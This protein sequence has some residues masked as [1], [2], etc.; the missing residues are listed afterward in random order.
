MQFK[1]CIKLTISP[2]WYLATQIL[3]CVTK[4]AGHNSV[5][6]SVI[7]VNMTA[8][9]T[10]TVVVG[11]STH[12]EELMVGEV[13]ARVQLEDEHVVDAGWAPAVRVDAEQEDHEEDEEQPAVHAQRRRPVRHVRVP[14]E[15]NCSQHGGIRGQQTYSAMQ[16]RD[17]CEILT[18]FSTQWMG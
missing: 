7:N 13:V 17:Q 10:H 6:R 15:H 4:L 8:L 12:L 2:A 9:A 11:A 16:R 18:S 3:S 1:R 5:Q 14:R